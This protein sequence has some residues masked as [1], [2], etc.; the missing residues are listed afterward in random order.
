MEFLVTNDG[1]VI[2]NLKRDLLP[3]YG[4]F[5]VLNALRPVEPGNTKNVIVQFQPHE[6]RGFE[7]TLRIYSETSSVSII[8][9][10]K[11]VK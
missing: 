4:G 8:L 1:N 6:Q 9:R 2:A 10:G 11:G 7:E 3:L 5:N